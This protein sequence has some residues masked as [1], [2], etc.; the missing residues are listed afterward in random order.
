[1]QKIYLD[2]S[3][4]TKLS[5]TVKKAMTKAMESFGNASSLHQEGRKSRQII[6][7]A[8]RQV[9]DL[10]NAELDEI[11]FTSG[12]SESNNTIINIAKEIASNSNKNEIIISAIEHHSLIIP[13]NKLNS[14]DIKVH[15]LPIDN[16][17]RVIISELEKII[18]K[19]TALVSIALANNE[20]GV[21]Q[22]LEKISIICNKN[23]ALL[24]SD[25]VQ[26]VGKINVDVK[27]LNLDY[28][29]ISAHKINGPKGVGAL[30]VKSGATFVPLITGGHQESNKRS[31]TENIIGIA[32]F[33]Q[34]ALDAKNTPEKYNSKILPLKNMLR[35]LIEIDISN[36]KINGDQENSLPNILNV[37]FFGAEGESIL[38]MLDHH[39]ISVS[40]GSACASDSTKPSHVL[41]AIKSD[42]ELAHGSIRF[43]FGLENTIEEVFEVIKCLPGIIEKLRK[44][45][46]RRSDLHG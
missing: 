41:M 12:G 30:Y 36:I 27:K 28:A 26:A 17:G 2:N 18:S 5:T 13:A 8:R 23:G 46:T 43:S 21:I 11:I 45:S 37:S 44:I 20:I 9:T 40:T 16:Q 7:T 32:G 14:N 39:G 1:M 6:E 31:G 34:A 29:S 15:Y 35:D 10:L 3:A 33:G 22:D 38:L 24:H 4:T 19:K 42:P 25:I